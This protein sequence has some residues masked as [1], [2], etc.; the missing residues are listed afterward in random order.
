MREAE[1]ED[2]AALDLAI[3]ITAQGRKRICNVY[4]SGG[5]PQELLDD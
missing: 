4:Q 5:G 2:V 1:E 3:A